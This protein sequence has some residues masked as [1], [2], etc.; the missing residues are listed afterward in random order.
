MIFLHSKQTVRYICQQ[1]PSGN[2][3]YFKQE[4]ITTD[5]WDQLTSIVWGRRRPIT[6]RTYEKRKKEGYRIFEEFIEKEQAIVLPFKK[7]KR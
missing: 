6:K 3:Y 1:Y 2:K 4:M 5:S 7:K